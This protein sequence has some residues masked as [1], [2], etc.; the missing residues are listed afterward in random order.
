VTLKLSEEAYAGYQAL[1]TEQGA[2]LAGI[3]E[4]FGLAMHQILV[5][6]RP[7]QLTYRQTSKIGVLARQVDRQRRARPQK[8]KE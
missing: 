8:S 7:A 3:V 1:A 6:H 4:A 2:T 5:E